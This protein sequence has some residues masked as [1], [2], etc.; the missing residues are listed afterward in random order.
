MVLPAASRVAR[1]AAVAT[2]L[3]VLLYVVSVPE[4]T[5]VATYLGL[6]AGAVAAAGVFAV[7]RLWT[8]RHIEGRVVAAGVALV[9]LTAQALN[10]TWGL[11]GASAL[12][13][14]L[15]PETV[16]GVVLE[17]LILVLLASEWRQAN[18][19]GDPDPYPVVHGNHGPDR[20]GR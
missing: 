10:L 8:G 18:G 12:A 20:R 11:P 7:L 1:S 9:S 13:D 6:A 14:R 15:L 5:G 17:V 4:L 16:V 3:L 2:G 19:A